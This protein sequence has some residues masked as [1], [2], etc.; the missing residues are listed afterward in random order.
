M[1]V[2]VITDRPDHPTLAAY[3]A[4]A[5]A[6]GHGVTFVRPGD[7]VPDIAGADLYLLKSRTP[8]ALL[9]G[10]QA[11]SAGI[12]IVNGTEATA[13]CLDRLE[14]AKRADAAG[15][16]F[17]PTYAFDRVTDLDAPGTLIL[18]TRHSHRHEPVPLTGT[19]AE[20]RDRARDWPDGPVIAQEFAEGDGWDHK[21]WVIG[22]RLFAG[23]RRSPLTSEG[24]G[25][26]RTH[27][28]E[29]IPDGV[30]TL[31]RTVGAHFGLTVYG[32]DIIATPHGPLIVDVNAFPGF[33]GLPEAPE[34]LTRL[35][36]GC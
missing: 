28:V 22:D 18:K 35:P 5:G 16:P 25:T 3:A 31:I 14:M 12:R 20:L 1:R 19:A 13:A 10:R 8:E 17:P 33:Q 2:R 4:L 24:Q 11:E 34:A 30:V 9:I 15:L 27:P 26:K 36:Q 6:R 29:D 7:P 23:L 21:F 32:V